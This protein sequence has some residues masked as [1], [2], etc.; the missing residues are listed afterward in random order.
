[1]LARAD[2]FLGHDDQ[3]KLE[4]KRAFDLAGNLSRVKKMEVE[5]GFY[6]ANADRAKAAEIYK[7]LFSLFPDSLDYGL[8]LAKL[9]LE[10]YRPDEALETIRQLRRLPPPARDDP[11]IDLREAGI[12]LSR[13][14]DAADRLYHSAADK[15]LAQ[16]KQLIYARAEAALCTM[17]RQHLQAPPE[18]PKA[19]EIF[20]AAGNRDSA[21]GCLQLMA[22]A[23]RVTGH[24]QEAMPLYEKAIRMFKEAGDREMIGV[25]LNNRALE[26]EDEGQWK[27]AEADFQEAL[28][29]FQAVNDKA[30]SGAAAS[31]IADLLFLRGRLHEAAGT[32]RESWELVDASGRGRSDGIHLRYGAMLLAQGEIKQ[33]RTE[34]EP[35]VSDLRK[36]GEAPDWLA[37]ALGLCDR[38]CIRRLFRAASRREDA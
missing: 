9:Q 16:G 17:N 34:I 22:E 13:D 21:G 3:A 12:V 19:Y 2:I 33:A 28:K 30:N 27:R 32:Y 5:A 23:N 8:Y 31:N 29:N 7:V 35:Q 14:A 4:A 38:L 36:Y 6:Q 10:S 1:M 37:D 15:A 26:L 11:A 24:R 20:L 18:C 25:G